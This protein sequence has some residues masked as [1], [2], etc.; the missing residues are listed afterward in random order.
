MSGNKIADIAISPHGNRL[1]YRK[2]QK[3]VNIWRISLTDT[4][5]IEHQ[6]GR[7]ISS[8]GLSDRKP[9]KRGNLSAYPDE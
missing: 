2:D 4:L 6:A 5:I 3:E 8:T 1:V 7:L 9:A